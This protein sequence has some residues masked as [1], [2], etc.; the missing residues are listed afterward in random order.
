[1]N[2]RAKTL[3][4]GLRLIADGDFLTSGGISVINMAAE[5]LE[6]LR[7]ERD[8]LLRKE[9]ALDAMEQHGLKVHTWEH[10]GQVFWTATSRDGCVCVTYTAPLE[11]IEAAVASIEGEKQEPADTGRCHTCGADVCRLCGYC[12]TEHNED[13]VCNC[14]GTEGNRCPATHETEKQEHGDDN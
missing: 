6:R 13:V 11:A 7:A 5:E 3:A 8:R 4:A 1:M 2:D 10:Y 14:P 9:A 12:L